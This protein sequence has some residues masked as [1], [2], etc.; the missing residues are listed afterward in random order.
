MLGGLLFYSS[1]LKATLDDDFEF[2]PPKLRGSGCPQ[3]TVSVAMSPEDTS[4]SILFDAFSAS[5]PQ[6]NGNN[7]N[8]DLALNE[9]EVS[10]TPGRFERSN[11]LIDHK[12]CNM[13]IKARIPKGYKIKNLKISYDFRGYTFVD[14]GVKAVFKS[15]FL[16]RKGLGANNNK[17]RLLQKKS[18]GK[19]NREEDWNI[20]Q[21]QKVPIKSK[22]A[23]RKDRTI[24]VKVKNILRARMTKKAYNK[25]RMGQI[26]M[27]SADI[28]GSIKY[29]FNLVKCK[30]NR[31][32]LR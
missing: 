21:T 7:D 2:S 11:P 29:K 4:M 1:T 18:W 20:H 6:F 10:P 28:A 17:K 30:K 15:I 31:R 13:I 5:V 8:E 19:G 26:V 16:H 9:E 32:N 22:C 14:P 25:D 12:V 27:D 23:R 24:K 3:D